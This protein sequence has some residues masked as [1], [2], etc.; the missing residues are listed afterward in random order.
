[1]SL[2]PQMADISVS[3]QMANFNTGPYGEPPLKIK[4][5]K[6]GFR[7]VLSWPTLGLETKFHEAVT[8]GGFGKHAQT[9]QQDS[10]FISID[11]IKLGS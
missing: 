4:I 2:G 7:H 11:Y 9:N 5:L 6:I 10:C 3:N 8:F 1:M